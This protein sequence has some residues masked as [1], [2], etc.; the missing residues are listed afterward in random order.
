MNCEAV[1]MPLLLRLQKN[2]R[3]KEMENGG[4]RKKGGG[5]GG[6]A[7]LPRFSAN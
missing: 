3:G 6:G 5:G 4:E 1:K 7:A 2:C